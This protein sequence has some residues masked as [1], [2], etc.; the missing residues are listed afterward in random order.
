MIEFECEKCGNPMKVPESAA[1]KK[2]I[3]KKCGEKMRVPIQNKELPPIVVAEPDINVLKRH[4][5][6]HIRIPMWMINTAIASVAVIV[7]AGLSMFFLSDGAEEPKKTEKI[8][9]ESEQSVAAIKGKISSGTGFLIDKN[10]LVTNRHVIDNQLLRYVT[11]HFPDAGLDKKG[12]HDTELL[13]VDKDNDLAFMRVN[14]ELPPL[15]ANDQFEFKR[16]KEVTVIGNPGLD[17]G[18][19]LQN[20]ISKGVMSSQTEID[21]RKYDQLSI[22]INPGNSGGPVLDDTGSVIGIV[23]LKANKQEG[24][25]FSIPVQLIKKRLDTVKSLT[26]SEIKKT[27]DYQNARGLF[28]YI[29]T[30]SLIYGLGMASYTDAMKAA[31]KK[32]KSATDGLESVR[33]KVLSETITI[34]ASVLKILKEEL[35]KLSSS[36]N[37]SESTKS[38]MVDLW[39]NYIEFKSYFDNPRGNVDSY[40]DKLN[41]LNDKH[42]RLSESLKL[43]LDI[44]Y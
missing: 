14:V 7:I 1:G 36:S 30:A 3:C 13:Y 33:E 34:D 21:G 10:I 43:L 26:S 40:S 11:V 29:N 24:L 39:A 41:E 42:T 27:Q 17:S 18:A 9:S 2:G 15:T 12:P 20:A 25:G 44:R 5:K 16:G 23:T 8:V 19:V 35:S 37:L 6:S 28:M 22:S 31:L 38:K 32:G 4:Q